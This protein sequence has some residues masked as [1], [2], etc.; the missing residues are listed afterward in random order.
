ML[1]RL[2]RTYLRPYGKPLAAVVVLQLAATIASLYLPSINGDIIDRGVAT[3]DTGYVLAMGGM[4]LAIAALQIAC[5]VTAVYI[6]ARVAMGYGRDLRLEWIEPEAPAAVEE[7]QRCAVAAFGVMDLDRGAGR[8][9][10]SDP[11]VRH[12]RSVADMLP[13]CCPACSAPTCA[14]TGAGSPPSSRSSS[15]RRSR[16]CTC[17]VST[18][19]SSIAASRP[20][21]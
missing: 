10:R 2:L 20:A 4:M 21:T 7:Q 8:E 11:D 6:G 12:A 17:R 14:R 18:P 16:R 3:G 13:P 1:L 15:W 5:S 9:R 19:T